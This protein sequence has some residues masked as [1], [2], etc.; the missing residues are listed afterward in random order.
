MSFYYALEYLQV[1]EGCPGGNQW[2]NLQRDIE[3]YFQMKN[4]KASPGNS[5]TNKQE[6]LPSIRVI[7]F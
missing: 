3:C 4:M 2:L 1:S 6:I 5:N 7:F